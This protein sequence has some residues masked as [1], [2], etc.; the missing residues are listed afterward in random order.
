[1]PLVKSE[2]QKSTSTEFIYFL[3]AFSLCAEIDLERIFGNDYVAFL[4]NPHLISIKLEI[5]LD[6][7]FLKNTALFTNKLKFQ[8]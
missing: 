1:M 8:A 6:T 7:F 2:R 4:I 3:S 5:F